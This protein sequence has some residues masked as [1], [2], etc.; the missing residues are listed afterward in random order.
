[1]RI[2]IYSI[3]AYS[4]TGKTTLI[5]KLIPAFRRPGLRVAVIK[6]DAHEFDI[7]RKGEG[8][9]ALIKRRRGGDSCRLRHEG[10]HYGKQTRP[11]RTAD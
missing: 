5:E 7:D 4:G 1:M 3:V 6:H 10:G 11:H 2:P 9:L 8:Q